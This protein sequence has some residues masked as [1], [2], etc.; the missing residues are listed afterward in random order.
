MEVGPKRRYRPLFISV[1]Q[2]TRIRAG[3]GGP[4]HRVLLLLLL[5]LAPSHSVS[6]LK[7]ATVYRQGA[8]C[9]KRRT[10][11]CFWFS[12]YFYF[13]TISNP[14]PK[15]LQFHILQNL[16]CAL[17]RDTNNSKQSVVH[18]TVTHTYQ[19]VSHLASQYCTESYY[20]KP[21]QGAAVGG[22]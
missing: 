16:L 18:C 8:L 22:E 9:F 11:R 10:E 3:R 5:V 1:I 19:T 12:A 2:N 6:E 13:L 20:R 7:Q 15:S 14:K 4:S 21:K 17:T